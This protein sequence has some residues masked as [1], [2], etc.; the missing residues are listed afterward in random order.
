LGLA[1]RVRCDKTKVL[2]GIESASYFRGVS[3]CR[4]YELACRDMTVDREVFVS[5]ALACNV[6]AGV[7]EVAKGTFVRRGVSVAFG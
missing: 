7:M 3:D 5:F 6:F 2:R 1:A 4:V